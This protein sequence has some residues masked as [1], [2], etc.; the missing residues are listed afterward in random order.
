MKNKILNKINEL[1]SKVNFSALKLKRDSK[2]KKSNKQKENK[3]FAPLDK[4]SVFNK[5]GLVVGEIILF[6]LVAG[7]LVM[8]VRGNPGNPVASGLTNLYWYKDGPF[9]LSPERGRFG[10]LFSL[11]EHKSFYYHVDVARFVVPDL[12]YKNGKYVSLFAPGVSYIVMPGYLIGRYFGSAQIGAFMAIAVFAL[13]NM[14]LVRAIAKELGANK[15]TSIIAGLIF[16]FATPAYAYAVNLYQHHISTFLILLSSLIVIKSKNA[17]PLF[18][19]WFLC[20]AS[21]PVDYPNLFLMFPVGLFALQKVID[22]R[23]DRNSIKI[24][25]SFLKLLTFSGLV[26]PLLF[27]FWFNYQS[28]GDP[29]QFSGTVGNAYAIDADGNPTS[30]PTNDPENIEGFLDPESQERSAVHFFESRDMLRGVYTHLIGP[31]RGIIFFTPI[32]LF[33]IIGAVILYKQNNKYLNMLLGVVVANF[34]LYSMWG[35][36]WGGWAFGSRY[37]IPSYAILAIFIA[38]A[39]T[40]INKR[41][42][43][44]MIMYPFLI[45]SIAVNTL[46]ALTTSAIPPKVEALPLEALTG[47]RERYSYDRSWEYLKAGKSK[48]FVFQM[49]ADN[50]LSSMQYYYIVSGAIAVLTT[51]FILGI[52][53]E[54]EKTKNVA[55][56]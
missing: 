22:I 33:G 52:V 38:V 10:L 9:E 16:V 41:K 50:Y 25:L 8:S 51:I 37:M 40:H 56:A 49:W 26:F 54:K 19:V 6:V 12:G 34:V 27:F 5:I 1:R 48:S 36:P 21:I 20:A 29:L 55:K 31:D 53:L 45:Y 35:D 3:I 32:I 46:G 43:L 11:V 44:A 47:V 14:Y 13:I 18:I 39:L 7:F 23:K 2:N 15:K 4:W 42:L 30:V 28:Y 24:N 17:W